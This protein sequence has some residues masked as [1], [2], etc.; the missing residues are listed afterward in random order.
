MK[1][2]KYVPANAQARAAD[3]DATLAIRVTINPRN[4]N[5][6][7]HR[8]ALPHEADKIAHEQGWVRLTAIPKAERAHYRGKRFREA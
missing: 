8:R 6:L 5:E 2:I 7:G 1:I 3:R 4:G